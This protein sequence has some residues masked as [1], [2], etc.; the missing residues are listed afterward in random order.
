M[1]PEKAEIERYSAVQQILVD[2]TGKE[3][4]A[5]QTACVAVGQLVGA[6]VLTFMMAEATMN[7]SAEAKGLLPSF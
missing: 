4:P 3:M 7:Q 1:T 6:G 5:L 2:W